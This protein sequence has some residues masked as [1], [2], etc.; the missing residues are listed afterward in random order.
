MEFTAKFTSFIKHIKAPRLNLKNFLKILLII[1]IV[2]ALLSPIIWYFYE[3][4]PRANI[5]CSFCHNIYPQLDP[6]H[7]K[8][9]CH[10]CHETT[11][12]TL[13]NSIYYYLTERPSDPEIFKKYH[14]LHGMSEPC[15][16]CHKEEELTNIPLHSTHLEIALSLKTCAICHIP[17]NGTILLKTDEK[18]TKLSYS[19]LC[20][21]CH[22]LDDIIKRHMQFHKEQFVLRFGD[23]ICTECHLNKKYKLPISPQCLNGIAKGTSC[24]SC[25]TKLKPPDIT[26]KSCLDCH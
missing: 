12:P 2:L 16:K 18:P 14:P 3:Y 5:L 7:S 8:F 23:Q 26:G 11:P 9:N 4:D 15:L 13:F 19:K 22:T 20:E 17:H 10:A 1:I 25:H 6:I 24:T 21:G